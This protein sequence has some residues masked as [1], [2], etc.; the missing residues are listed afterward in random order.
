MQYF[1]LQVND[2]IALKFYIS[3]IL[4]IKHSLDI[5]SIIPNLNLFYLNGILLYWDFRVSV[6]FCAV[7]CYLLLFSEMFLLKWYILQE[8]SKFYKFLLLLPLINVLPCYMTSKHKMFANITQDNNNVEVCEIRIKTV[9]E[10]FSWNIFPQRQEDKSHINLLSDFTNRSGE[11]ILTP[12]IKQLVMG[13]PVDHRRNQ[14][15][16]G[17]KQV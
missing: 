17:S 12:V 11:T 1:S 4:N 8:L 5:K 3:Y 13:K 2:N 7:R 10:G 9:S 6:C 16:P 15:I 14:N